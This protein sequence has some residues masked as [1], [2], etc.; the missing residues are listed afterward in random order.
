MNLLKKNIEQHMEY[1]ASIPEEF[2][3]KEFDQSGI[4]LI[5]QEIEERE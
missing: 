4:A 2:P 3:D 5:I 1:R